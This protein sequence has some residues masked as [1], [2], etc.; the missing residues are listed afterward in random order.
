MFFQN[1]TLHRREDCENNELFTVA[2]E[3]KLRD[4]KRLYNLL[5]LLHI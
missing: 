1:I 2:Y 5:P 4:I 3:T